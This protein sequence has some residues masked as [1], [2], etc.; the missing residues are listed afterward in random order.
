MRHNHAHFPAPAL[1][2]CDIKIVVFSQLRTR[3]NTLF[4]VFFDLVK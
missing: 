2:N 4:F 3:T 1:G